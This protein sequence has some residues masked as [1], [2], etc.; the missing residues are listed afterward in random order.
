MLKNTLILILRQ[1]EYKEGE[2]KAGKQP[3]IN[4]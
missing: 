1:E 4:N 3:G 2:T